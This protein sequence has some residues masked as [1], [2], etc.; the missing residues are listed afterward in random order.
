MK[1]IKDYGMGIGLS[2]VICGLAYLGAQFIPKI[3]AATLAILLGIALGNTLFKQNIWERGT[4][5]TEK[6]FLE[7]SI[8]LLGLS[9]T[10]QTLIDLGINAFLFVV[11]LMALTLAFVYF[12]AQKMGFSKNFAI[13]MASGNAVCGSSAI[14]SVAPSIQASRDDKGSSITITNLLGTILMLGLPIIATTLFTSDTQIGA[15]LGGTIQSVGQVAGAASSISKPVFEYAMIFKIIRVLM[16]VFVVLL[17]GYVAGK[18][19]PSNSQ[20]VERKFSQFV[21]WYIL[22][23]IVV[24]ILNSMALVPVEIAQPLSNVSTFLEV[25]ALAA[26]GLRL[27][28]RVLIQSGR[29]LIMLAVAIGIFQILAASALIA[30]LL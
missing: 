17:W 28:I 22:G 23:F 1:T 30:I 16:L 27:N 12:L 26:I 18:D 24:C 3:G 15:L 2:I 11:I 25:S 6:R 5:F 4:G 8:V 14:A 13:L 7:V 29:Q 19:V 9:V 20:K 21:P 10:T